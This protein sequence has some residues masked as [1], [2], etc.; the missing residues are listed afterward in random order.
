MLD[1]KKSLIILIKGHS[2]KAMSIVLDLQQWA[3]LEF[4]RRIPLQKKIDYIIV[5][6][7]CKRLMKRPEYCIDL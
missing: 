6:N 7:E 5:R 3:Y 2:F 1:S 4:G